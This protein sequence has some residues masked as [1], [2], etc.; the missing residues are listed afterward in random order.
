MKF[1]GFSSNLG[2]VFE[3]EDEEDEVSSSILWKYDR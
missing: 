1:S 3:E 2:A